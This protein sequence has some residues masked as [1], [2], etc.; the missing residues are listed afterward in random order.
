MRP[1]YFLLLLLELSSSAL[2][3]TFAGSGSDPLAQTSVLVPG[4]RGD[5]ALD[6][7]LADLK[8]IFQRFVPGLD[9]SSEIVKP[10]VVSGSPNRPLVTVSI[11]KCVAFLCQTVDLDAS[12]EI[13]ELSGPCA[14]N[15]LL[16][17]D[18]SRSSPS[19]ADT[20]DRLDVIGCYQTRGDGSGTLYLEASAH[21]APRYS[22]GL[23][24]REI[25]KML[26]LQVAPIT[27]AIQESLRARNTEF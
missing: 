24:Q 15:Y 6:R 2:A 21:Q 13:R 26:G 9:S 27:K 4:P 22:Q 5:A 14:R 17:V 3:S 23:V 1:L 8:G 20:Y 19:L 11:R 18:L 25:V 12:A 16:R 7:S 10:L